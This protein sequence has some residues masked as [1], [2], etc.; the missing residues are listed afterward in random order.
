[1]EER[2][3]T[4]R[5]GGLV[6]E[7]IAGEEAGSREGFFFKGV[8][9]TAR[10]SATGMIQQKENMCTMQGRERGRLHTKVPGTGE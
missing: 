9:M 7:V 4:L 1:M 3:E 2:K 5:A 10:V 8:E 6:Q